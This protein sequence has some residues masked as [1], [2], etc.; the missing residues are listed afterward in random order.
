MMT[1]IKCS[2][3]ITPRD[4]DKNAR[5]NNRVI[6]NKYCDE[7]RKKVKSEK[8][9]MRTNKRVPLRVLAFGYKA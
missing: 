5:M 1:C 4:H 9:R 8:D 3:E 6:I 7:C 2:C